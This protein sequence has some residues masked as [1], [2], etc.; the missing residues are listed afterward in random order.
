MK[1][2]SVSKEKA[3]LNDKTVE[4]LPKESFLLSC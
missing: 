3:K 1:G 4:P 2:L